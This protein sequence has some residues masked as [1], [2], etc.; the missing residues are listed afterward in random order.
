MHPAGILDEASDD[1]HG[2]R[3]R[4][5][6]LGLR[7]VR[8]VPWRRLPWRQERRSL[9]QLPHRR[10]DRVRDLPPATARRPAPTSPTAPRSSACAE[11]H[12]MPARWD[13]PGHIVGDR[14]P[15]E[16]DVRRARAADAGRRRAPGPTDLRGRHLRQRV[17]PR[18]RARR[19]AAR[20]TRPRWDRAGTVGLC[21]AATARRRRAT[22]RR[23]A[24]PVTRRR[25]RTSTASRRSAGPTAAMAATAPR[26]RPHRRS[27]SRATPSRP[28]SASART[29]RTCRRCP[30]CA[31]RS[32]ARRATSCPPRSTRRATSTRSRPP[33][34]RRASAGIVRPRPARPRG[35]TARRARCGPR[36]ALAARRAAPAT[37][38]RR[39]PPAIPRACRSPAA[40]PVIPQSVE[41]SGAI[42]IIGGASHHMDGDRRC[43]L[44]RSS[45]SPWSPPP[46]LRRCCCGT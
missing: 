31:G 21:D 36:S 17:L 5:P 13:A 9:H 1:F 30:G 12:T 10:T 28:R 2:A 32:R 18:R 24:R 15:A 25:R 46:A 19:P 43:P 41:P 34:S 14:A 44:T 37:A 6:G 40:P 45:C 22:P 11:C 38:C 26:R 42:R 33:R 27:I 16:V 7:A 39:S 8:D 35:V 4:A 29:R 20:S 23:R 3:A